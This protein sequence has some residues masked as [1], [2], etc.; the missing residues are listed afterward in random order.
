MVVADIENMTRNELLDN[1]KAF[2]SEPAPYRISVSFMRQVLAF[3][4]QARQCGGLSKAFRKRLK[5]VASRKNHRRPRHALPISTRL[6]REWNGVPHV[7]EV[8]EQGFEW[9]GTTYKSL[10]AIAREITGAHWSGPR[11]FGLGKDKL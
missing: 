7:V 2:Y 3:E 10:S 8:T 5:F 1:W 6:V 11:F 9:K 4:L